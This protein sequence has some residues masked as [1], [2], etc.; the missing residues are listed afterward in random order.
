MK[1]RYAELDVSLFRAVTEKR[2]P[3]NFNKGAKFNSQVITF[4]LHVA[5][6]S[7][8][9]VVVNAPLSQRWWASCASV[10]SKLLFGWNLAD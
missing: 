1:S 5:K 7:L 8:S 4:I 3:G 6:I 2:G 10:L 9:R